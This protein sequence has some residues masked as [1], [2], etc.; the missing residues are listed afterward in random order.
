MQEIGREFEKL[1]IG[2]SC[3]PQPAPA[4]NAQTSSQPI[5]SQ[6]SG[7]V[8]SADQSEAV[9]SVSNKT[10]S[11]LVSSDS[12]GQNDGGASPETVPSVLSLQSERF[13]N[14]ASPTEL[15]IDDTVDNTIENGFDENCDDIEIGDTDGET[16]EIFVNNNETAREE[17]EEME[18]MEMT[19]VETDDIPPDIQVN[20][21]DQHSIKFD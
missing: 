17:V 16:I 18:E 14:D 5:R 21:M 3:K 19:V 8:I 15:V 20:D 7:H 13:E 10:K 6:D 12:D 1:I 2:G 9:P 11:I 4:P